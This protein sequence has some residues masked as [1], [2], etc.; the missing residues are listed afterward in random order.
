MTLIF[1]AKGARARVHFPSTYFLY[2]V[3]RFAQTP[4]MFFVNIMKEKNLKT[5]KCS[6]TWEHEHVYLLVYRLIREITDEKMEK[7]EFSAGEMV[8]EKWRFSRQKKEGKTDGPE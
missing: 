4:S 3:A 6:A 5:Q 2:F 7:S 8:I 1:D